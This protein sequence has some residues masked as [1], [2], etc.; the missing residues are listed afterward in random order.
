M[1]VIN[2]LYSFFLNVTKSLKFI[3]IRNGKQPWNPG[4]F[5]GVMLSCNDMMPKTMKSTVIGNTCATQ[6]SHLKSDNQPFFIATYTRALCSNAKEKWT[7]K[8]DLKERLGGLEYISEIDLKIKSFDLILWMSLF[9]ITYQIFFPFVKLYQSI[10]YNPVSVISQSKYPSGINFC[11]QNLPLIYIESC[12]VQLYL[13]QNNLLTDSSLSD[14]TMNEN[15][16]ANEISSDVLVLQVD[17][18]ILTS[19][20]ENPLSRIIIDPEIYNAALNSKSLSLP[21]AA[22]EDRQYQVDIN[23]LALGSRK[24]FILFNC[25]CHVVS[26]LPFILFIYCLLH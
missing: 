20:V 17:S 10:C 4:P 21:G 1:I 14:Q 12:I 16:F 7:S 19:Q 13:P 9:D 25:F 15:Q 2:R 23:G 26:L 11:N 18:I 3:L 22:V 8:E 24:Y 5:D 6:H